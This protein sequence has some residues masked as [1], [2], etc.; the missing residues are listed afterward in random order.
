M[1]LVVYYYYEVIARE[2]DQES[3]ASPKG[4]LDTDQVRRALD[5]DAVA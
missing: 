5:E 4:V 2:N 1:Y 3:G